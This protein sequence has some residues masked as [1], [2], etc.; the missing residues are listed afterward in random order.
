MSTSKISTLALSLG[1]LALAPQFTACRSNQSVHSQMSDSAI[2]TSV[3][4]KLIANNEVKARN[5]DVNTE[6]G[7]VYLMGRVDSQSEKATAERIARDCDGVTKV[8][9]HLE[10][11]GH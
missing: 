2:T 3:K 6:E 7:V 1:I 8:V 9:N 4:T 5:I 11:G 10:V